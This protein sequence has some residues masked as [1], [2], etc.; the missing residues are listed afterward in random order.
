M[1]ASTFKLLPD[2]HEYPVELMK[3]REKNSTRVLERAF[4]CVPPPRGSLLLHWLFPT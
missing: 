2:Y 1:A 3:R 4:I